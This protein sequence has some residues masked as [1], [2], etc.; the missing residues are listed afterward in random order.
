MLN[1]G[2]G[3]TS[4]CGVEYSESLVVDRAT[5]TDKGQPVTGQVLLSGIIQPGRRLLNIR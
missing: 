3:F 5:V 4:G 2:C 1:T